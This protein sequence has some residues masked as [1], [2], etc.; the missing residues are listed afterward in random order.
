[1]VEA[2]LTGREQVEFQLEGVE[3]GT[4]S[5]WTSFSLW[6]NHRELKMGEGRK[7]REKK[8]TSRFRRSLK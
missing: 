4:Q 7:K 6:F 5:F 3:A 2:E 1:M 8:M